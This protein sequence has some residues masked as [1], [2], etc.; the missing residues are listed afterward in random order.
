VSIIGNQTGSY[1]APYNTGVM[2]QLV[3]NDAS[4][5]RVY[6]DSYGS[7][8][9]SAFIGRS[10]NGTAEVPLA[11][12]PGDIIARFGANP[13]ATSGGPNNG[14][15]YAAYSTARIDMVS[16]ENQTGTTRG[17]RI[18]FWT[19]PIGSN[20]VANIVSMSAEGVTFNISSNVTINSNL[21]VTG[22]IISTGA[23]VSRG[24]AIAYGNLLAYG[25]T[26]THGSLITYGH[27]QISGTSQFLGDTIATKGI[28]LPDGS[29][30]QTAG[31]STITAGTG[32]S[33]VPGAGYSVSIDNTGIISITGTTNQVSVTNLSGAVT[34]SLPQSIATTSSPQFKNL[35]VGNLTVTGNVTSS[36]ATTLNVADKTIYAAN[37]AVS[38]SA[39]DGGGFV[40]GSDGFAAS[41][42]YTQLNDSWNL[43]KDLNVNNVTAAYT[44]T[45][46]FAYV[47][48]NLLVGIQ[49]PNYFTNAPIQVASSDN[50][51]QQLNNQ[52]L[53]NGTNASTDYIATADIGDDSNYYIDF[54]IN[55]S[56]YNQVAY[57]IG[58]ALDGYLYI[59]GGNLTVGTQ[60]TGK[61]LVF[62]TDGTTSSNIAGFVTGGR[63]IFGGADDGITKVQ[64][65]GAVSATGNV[66]ASNFNGTSV[67]VTNLNGTI[68]QASQPNITSL[69][70]L[71]GLS[72]GSDAGFATNISVANYA[73]V[74]SLV[75]NAGAFT[76][77]LN[78]AGAVTVNQLTSNL[79]VNTNTLQT[80]GAATVNSLIANAGIQSI[81]TIITQNLVSN[82]SITASTINGTGAAQFASIISNGTI[83]SEGAVTVASLISNVMTTSQFLNVTNYAQV[84]R[85]VSN[86]DVVAS[87]LNSTGLASVASL[88]SNSSIQAT[89]IY[90][91][92]FQGSTAL[93]NSIVSNTSVSSVTLVASGSGIV[94]ALYSN[95]IVQAATSVIAN[96][97]FG[98]VVVSAPAVVGSSSV[99][100]GAITSNSTIQAASGVVA[101]TLFSN[102]SIFAQSL[103][104]AGAS[105]SGTLTSN[106]SISGT[107]LTVTSVQSSGQTLTNSLISNGV[108][109]TATL[110][111][112]GQATINSIVNN[113]NITTTNLNS[114]GQTTVASLVSNGAISGTSVTGTA[115]TFTSLQSSGTTLVQSLN[116]NTNVVATNLQST[117]QTTV[118][119]LVSNANTTTATLNSTG[120]AQVNSL[121]S[122]TTIQGI[123]TATVN[124]LVSNVY[125]AFGQ[126]VS[127]SSTNTS[128]STSTG[129]LTVAGGV[130]IQGNVYAQSVTLSAGTAS[131]YPLKFTSASALLNPTQAGV[132]NYDGTVFYATPSGL[133]RGVIP[134]NQY[135]VLNS[136]RTYTP[137]SGAVSSIFGVGVTLTANTR[138]QFT[139]IANA[140]N[141]AGGVSP[142]IAWGGN[143][144][145][146]Q[147]NYQITTFIAALGTATINGENLDNTITSNFSTGV[148]ITAAGGAGQPAAGTP[149]SF[150][151]FGMVDVGASG[152]T[153]IPELGWSG[154]PGTVT[155]GALSRMYISPVSIGGGNTSVGTWA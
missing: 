48:G 87:N 125:G 16:S 83:Q 86:T 63:W 50:T 105:I 21:N 7:R 66:T 62:H 114:T 134:V 76:Q 95:S 41:L 17:S 34:L 150:T 138:Y 132:V 39:M 77:S 28:V 55:S 89:T 121:I 9:Y 88:V 79:N 18:E 82:A 137:G 117:G 45:T 135:Y 71:N 53:N 22:A 70:V 109:Q 3:G 56:N 120:A 40:L 4:N 47:T 153:F 106:G 143:A 96:S 10:A 136:N 100:A 78:V 115:G 122:N 33:V 126:N 112:S 101:Q 69:G 128:I 44:S 5:A 35:T 108:V 38:T 67:T 141:S 37:G 103:N 127:V 102:S 65:N 72:V 129:A 151:L 154:N 123:G 118:A 36:E 91:G 147:V 80:A 85:L 116:S 110:I 155:V 111:S 43:N 27:T 26:I 14:P 75:V 98:N 2:L 8:T 31:V 1:V 81:D 29:N 23:I 73:R 131:Q 94:S 149:L 51:S 42:I 11:Y 60:T 144:T 145:L 13:Y 148:N 46:Q 57:S 104:I 74:N 64:V 20:V 6:T 12:G 24:D 97:V 49:P 93:I 68:S 92:S 52:N 119:S 152:G 133:Q 58:H 140:S 124:T 59:N 107:A 30:I 15:G 25:N 113:T 90:S 84:N 54:G 61:K 19:T 130:G 142:N 32:I 146:T 99:L 139:I